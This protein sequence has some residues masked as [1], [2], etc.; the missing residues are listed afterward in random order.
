MVGMPRFLIPLVIVAVGVIIYSLVECLTTPKHNVRAMPKA[1]WVLVILLVPAVGALLWLFLGRARRQRAATGY[2]PAPKVSSPDDD[3]A[4][5]RQLDVQRRQKARQADL[6]R[7]EAELKARE[8]QARETAKNEPN[9]Q[10][11]TSPSADPSAATKD[12][13]APKDVQAD[14]SS[15]ETSWEVPDS[16]EGLDFPENP[17]GGTTGSGG[18]PPRH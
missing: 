5:L 18:T 15:N 2:G 4:F 8:Q 1:A 6:D 7:R 9:G 13:A 12:P 10:R 3:E 14:R 16:L 17:D 11:S